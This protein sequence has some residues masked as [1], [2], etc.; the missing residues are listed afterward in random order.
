MHTHLES[1][2]ISPAE[3]QQQQ[4]LAL[5]SRGRSAEMAEHIVVTIDGPAG[6]GKSTVARQLA[7]RLGFEYLNTGAMYRAIALSCLRGR[8]PLTD[9]AAVNELTERTELRF[10][11]QRLLLNQVDV[12]DE[13]FTLTVTEAASIVAAI[14]AVRQQLVRL[15]RAAAEGIHLVTEGRDQGTI[16]FPDAPC[17]FFLTAT[18]EVRALRRHEELARGGQVV[19]FAVV[20]A[21]QIERDRRD[22]S[23]QVA[24]LVAADDA[25][26]IDTSDFSIEE[27]VARLATVVEARC[28]R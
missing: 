25:Q 4:R 7:Q 26:I 19:E 6:T 22:Q 17:K 21:D 12:T 14:P 1:T 18:P 23:R 3:Q 20:L 16:V 28:Q 13:L 11:R 5:G 10:E 27:V 24:P 9:H 15:Q 8:V 2:A